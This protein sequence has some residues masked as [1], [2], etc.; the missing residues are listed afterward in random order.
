MKKFVTLLLATVLTMSLL[1]CFASAED[2]NP[3]EGLSGELTMYASDEPEVM[4]ALTAAF[5]ELTGV[6]VN[7]VY[8]G[9]GEIMARVEAEAAHPLGD[10]TWGVPEEVLLPYEDYIY[11]YIETT[12]DFSDLIYEP[13]YDGLYTPSDT[14]LMVLLVNKDLLDEADIPTKWQDLADPKYFGKIAFADPTATSSGYIQLNILQQLYGW[15][16]VK[17]F[18]NNL[19]GRIQ[20]GSSKPPKLTSDGEY[21]VALTIETLAVDYQNASDNMVMIYP[22]D[23]TM[24]TLCGC[25]IIKDCPNLDAAKAW[26]EFLMTDEYT[27]IISKFQV[28]GP[29]TDLVLLEGLADF[30]DIAFMDYD[31]EAAQNREEIIGTW[32]D[33]MIGKY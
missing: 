17:D 24:K 13:R 8:G 15:D 20:D 22:E 1:G 31:Y 12:R 25:A 7:I 11:K 19:D 4:E 16:F 6:T 21:A 33:I 18:Y 28:R 5:T 26:C 2:A 27:E 9:G 10:V 3:F 23:G 14:N 29:R 30:A 32:N